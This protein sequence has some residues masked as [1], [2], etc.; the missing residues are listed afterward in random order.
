MR[1][2][3][4]G[5]AVRH[6]LQSDLFVNSKHASQHESVKYTCILSEAAFRLR[7]SFYR[8][9]THKSS[10]TVSAH[11]AK[12]HDH[13]RIRAAQRASSVHQLLRPLSVSRMPHATQ[14]SPLQAAA[15]HNSP[16]ATARHASRRGH[17]LIV[18]PPPCP[19]YPPR[20]PPRAARS[21]HRQHLVLVDER[22]FI[23][24]A[25]ISKG[26]LLAKGAVGAVVGRRQ[27]AHELK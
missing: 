25:L 17:H 7:E 5:G 10:M 24:V 22:R 14:I 13:R 2:S 19:L 27:T 26:A 9:G 21:A 6:C 1:P 20:R 4:R 3:L 18:P 8:Y 11:Q 12:S 16:P 23:L 15:W